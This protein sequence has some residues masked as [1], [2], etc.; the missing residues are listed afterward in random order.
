MMRYI[1]RRVVAIIPS[2][3]ILY[4]VLFLLIRVVPGDIV[5]LYL[6]GGTHRSG[7]DLEIARN[8]LRRELGLDRS[9][10]EQYVIQVT[11]ILRGDFGDSMRTGKPVVS[12]IKRRAPITI[13]LTILATLI[14]LA[15]AFP[16][17]ILSAVYR[18]SIIDQ[19]AR[20][21]SVLA[22]SVPNFW[23]GT[24]ILLLPAIMWGYGPP[25]IYQLPWENLSHNL[26]QILP[27]SVALGA[28]LGGGVTRFVR[29]SL[30]E[31][32]RQDYLRTAYAKGLTGSYVLRRHALKN[33]MIPVL[34][35]VGL[36]IAG[37]LGGSVITE[38]VFNIPGLGTLTVSA[39]RQRDYT[40]LEANILLF[41]VIVAATTLI[42]DIT[43]A[44]LDP[45]IVWK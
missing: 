28:S 44:W 1:A 24:L 17:G 34:T 43:Y 26:R 18:G 2:L 13:E 32:L 19:T 7:E 27:A 5:D 23:L 33:A 40:Q 21:V 41:G 36:Q 6:E 20:G 3:V 29:S 25:A 39:I 8:A 11:G 35:I 37:L 12:E 14:A 4:T 9:L 16:F 22:L 15:I 38:A 30:L 45:R 31:V 10:P 42:I